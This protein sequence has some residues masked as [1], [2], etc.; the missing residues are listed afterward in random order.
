MNILQFHTG[1]SA[2]TLRRIKSKKYEY[3]ETI[4]FDMADKIVC[5]TVGP[6]AW[7]TEPLSEYYGPLTVKKYERDF[8]HEEVAA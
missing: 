2:R 5:G 8:D 3:A 1:V 4:P 6:L 7:H